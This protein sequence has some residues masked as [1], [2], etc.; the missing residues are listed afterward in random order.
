MLNFAFAKKPSQNNKPGSIVQE[1]RF[2][3]CD[4]D[5]DNKKK[6]PGA[7]LSLFKN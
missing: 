6:H 1:K 4:T 5:L 7:V 3:K 2:P